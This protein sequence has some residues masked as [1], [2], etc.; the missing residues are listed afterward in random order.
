[1]I[2]LV[3]ALVIVI[4]LCGCSSTPETAQVAATTLPVY[5]F[6]ATICEG[7]PISVTQLVTE[8]VS[9]LHDYSLN[10]RQVRAAESADVV[11]ISGGGLED[12]MQDLL[13]QQGCIIDASTGLD[14]NH[15]EHAEEL[16]HDHN[17][18][19]PHFWLS[20]THAK[21]MAENICNG[22]IAQY[23]EY[24]ET[25]HRNLAILQQKLDQLLDYGNQ[26]LTGLSCRK[27][28]TFHDGFSYFAEA[29]D[30][31]IIKSMEEETGS[32]ASASELK[33]LIQLQQQHGIPAVFIE[34]NGSVSA[35]NILRA[36]TGVKIYKLDMA[37]SGEDYLAAMYRNIDTIKEA[38]G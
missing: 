26:Q 25:F 22:L 20:P 30:L 19:D 1:M 10:V 17:G 5:E 4:F 23:P 2:K 18:C 33:E 34:Q 16:G 36:E 29:F 31:T 35:A 38:L 3:V 21:H 12:F 14:I 8:T 27:L 15:D 32:E 11:V 9:C 24:D 28:I 7:T 6:T 13:A 37:I